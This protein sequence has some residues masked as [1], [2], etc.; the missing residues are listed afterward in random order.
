MQSE[1][2]GNYEKQTYSDIYPYIQTS[3]VIVP[4]V[5]TEASRWQNLCPPGMYRTEYSHI[6]NAWPI[7]SVVDIEKE[8]KDLKPHP[9]CN[10][11][12]SIVNCETE[13]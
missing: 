2:Q 10:S 11:V 8:V 12:D 1:Y 9:L 4:E 5:I 6:G 3:S 7:R 13:I